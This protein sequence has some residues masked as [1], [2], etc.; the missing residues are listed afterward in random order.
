MAYELQIKVED[1]IMNV[2]VRGERDY[3]TIKKVTSEILMKCKENKCFRVLIDVRDFKNRIDTMEIFFLASADLP[4]I[5]K[6]KLEKVAIIDLKG[7]EEKIKFF[8]DVARNRG[9]NVRIFTEY[10]EAINWLR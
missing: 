4:E 6:R 9:H 3:E 1:R 8:E 2:H 7:F 10:D 5:I